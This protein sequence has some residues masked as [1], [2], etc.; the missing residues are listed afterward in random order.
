MAASEYKALVNTDTERPH[1]FVL[2]VRISDPH[3]HGLQNGGITEMKT[4]TLYSNT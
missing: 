4:A 1:K 3:I 2:T